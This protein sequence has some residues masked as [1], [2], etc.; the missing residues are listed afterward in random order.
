M[1]NINK[2]YFNSPYYFLIREKIDKYSLYFSIS[3]TLSEARDND[4]VIHFDKKI[5][6]S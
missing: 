3:N 5:S 6:K 2:E 1:I 4:E